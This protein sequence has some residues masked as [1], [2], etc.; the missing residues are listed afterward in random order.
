MI[1]HPFSTTVCNALQIKETIVG[2]SI[3]VVLHVMTYK[4]RFVCNTPKWFDLRNHQK[5]S[6]W[7]QKEDP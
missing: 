4:S 1:T 6:Y 3:I 5:V 2:M 7:V